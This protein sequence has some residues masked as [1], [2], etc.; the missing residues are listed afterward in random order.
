MCTS[1]HLAQVNLNIYIYISTSSQKNLLPDIWPI[2]IYI[3]CV[4][5]HS[6]GFK[7]NYIDGQHMHKLQG[8]PLIN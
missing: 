6:L 4:Y 2:A 8:G 3:P 1:V 5:E 7:L